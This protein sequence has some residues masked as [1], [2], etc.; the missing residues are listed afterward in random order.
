[1]VP[2]LAASLL[3]VVA[4]Q[5]PTLG[6]N[7]AGVAAVVPFYAAFLIVMAFAGKAVAHLFRLDAPASRAIVSPGRPA[8][9]SSCYPSPWRCPATWPSPRSSVS[10]RRWSR[11]AA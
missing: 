9:P 7:L 3:T 10:P 6:D 2:L 4:S 11:F 8:T 5:M 1:M